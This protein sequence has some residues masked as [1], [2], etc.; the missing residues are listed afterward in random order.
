[1]NIP[2][3]T[4]KSII[5]KLKEYGTTT[6]L[7]REGFPPKLTVQARRAL[8]RGNKETKD[9]PE[10]AATLH[11]GD[12]SI[13]PQDHCNPYTS[14]SWALRKSGQ[15][16]PLFKKKI[17]KHV[18]CSPKGMWETLQTYGRRYFSYGREL[19]GNQGKRY[20]WCK[21]NTSQYPENTIVV[22]AASCCGDVFYR[23]RLR[24]WSELK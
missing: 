4:I 7:P 17:R 1:M 19:F 12:W 18:W 13:C 21:S 6:N 22:V 3:S 11:S 20:V 24:N 5:K 9:N 16:K 14:H 15:K 2:R 8:I 23:Q 10:G